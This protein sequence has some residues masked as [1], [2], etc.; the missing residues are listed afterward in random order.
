MRTWKR[1]TFSGDSGN[2]AEVALGAPVGV[3]DSKAPGAVLWV[4]PRAWTALLGALSGLSE[5]P[6]RAQRG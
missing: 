1:S 5:Q 2:C 4:S 3:R 6:P